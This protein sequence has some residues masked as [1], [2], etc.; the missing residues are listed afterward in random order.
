MFTMVGENF[1]T[2]TSEMARNGCKK[3]NNRNFRYSFFIVG[4]FVYSSV[5]SPI[6]VNS[7]S[8]RPSY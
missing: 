3:I 2:Y 5:K 4:L 1:E 7:F 6:F 8:P